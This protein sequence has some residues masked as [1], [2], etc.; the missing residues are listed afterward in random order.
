MEVRTPATRLCAKTSPFSPSAFACAAKL[1][2]RL[3]AKVRTS[4]ERARMRISAFLLLMWSS[5]SVA[6]VPPM[7]IVKQSRKVMRKADLVGCFVVELP[8]NC[9]GPVLVG[10]ELVGFDVGAVLLLDETLIGQS[11][12]EEVS[13][14]VVPSFVPSLCT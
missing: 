1:E 2:S 5:E 13:L 12:L 9:T 6:C 14:T 3:A 4:S 8:V 10:F 7:S 11:L